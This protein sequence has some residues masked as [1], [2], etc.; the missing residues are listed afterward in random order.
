MIK[1]SIFLHVFR[2]VNDGDVI[3]FFIVV[4]VSFHFE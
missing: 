2:N 4:D 1:L 3:T